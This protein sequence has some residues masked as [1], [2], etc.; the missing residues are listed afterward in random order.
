MEEGYIKF[1]LHWENRDLGSDLK[2]DALQQNRQLMYQNGLIGWDEQLKVGFGN[3]S[4]RYQA[5]TTKFIISGTQTGE[6]DQLDQR[7]FCLVTSFDIPSN[8]LWCQGPIKASSESMTHAAVY[9]LE[10]Q[11]QAVIHIHHPKMW[12]HYYDILPTTDPGIKYGTPE[13]A[14]AI[15]SLAQKGFQST[16]PLVIMGG[17]QDGILAFGVNLESV[18][19]SILTHF[20]AFSR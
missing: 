13:M 7:H 19:V 4:Q 1:Q 11:Y 8:Q 5:K 10:K 18:A 20:E 3:I 17:H 9:T 2:L 6:L 15:I 14:H 12:E 16:N